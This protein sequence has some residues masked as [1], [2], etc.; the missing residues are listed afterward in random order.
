[1][2]RLK[3]VKILILKT[4]PLKNH[5]FWVPMEAKMEPK[6]SLESIFIA[7][8]NDVEKVMLFRG[9]GGR[10]GVGHGR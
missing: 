7:I 5:Y 3:K 1:M 8:E 4:T 6:W 10:G 9:A 2:I